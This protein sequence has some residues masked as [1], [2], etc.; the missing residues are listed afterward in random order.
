MIVKNDAFTSFDI[1]YNLI[2]PSEVLF[3]A[4][5]LV[6]LKP[7]LKSLKLYVGGGDKFLIRILLNVLGNKLENL[8]IK[9]YKN[10]SFTKSWLPESIR[11]HL[12]NLVGTIDLTNDQNK[13]KKRC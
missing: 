8:E 1:N 5:S 2:Q 10:V 9:Q 13:E 12:L 3:H 11:R 4:R 7:K 6:W